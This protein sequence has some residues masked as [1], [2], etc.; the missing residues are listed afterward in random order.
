MM[1]ALKK[2]N[3]EL[4]FLLEVLQNRLQTALQIVV[5]LISF[6]IR[7]YP[8][9]LLQILAF[10]FI[11]S[12]LQAATLGLVLV[13]TRHLEN[14]D[15]INILDLSLNARGPLA[16]G[17]FVS[18]FLTLM[19]VSSVMVF[20]AE[21]L[22]NTVTTDLEASCTEDVYLTL[23][24]SSH[25]PQTYA[26]S[27][28]THHLRST[29]KG[30]PRAVGRGLRVLLKAITPAITTV[31]TLVLALYIN[32]FA[33]LISGILFVGFMLLQFR[34]YQDVIENE[35]RFGLVHGRSR[36]AMNHLLDEVDCMPFDESTLRAHLRYRFAEIDFYEAQKAYV[37]RMMANNRSMFAGNLYLTVAVVTTLSY[38]GYRGIT[39]EAE[40]SRIITYLITLRILLLSIRSLFAL[41]SGL[42]RLSLKISHIQAFLTTQAAPESIL[43]SPYLEVHLYSDSPFSD[44]SCHALRLLQGKPYALMVP[45][46]V[47][48][49][50]ENFFAYHLLGIERITP[51][52][53]IRILGR[54]QTFPVDA[55]LAQLLKVNS[56]AE[57]QGLCRNIPG[58]LLAKVLKQVVGGTSYEQVANYRF[59]SCNGPCSKTDSGLGSW[60]TLKKP[61][62][63]VLSF[64]IIFQDR[65]RFLLVDRVF[66]HRQ[67]IWWS[68]WMSLFS[69]CF[70]FVVYNIEYRRNIGNYGEN[71]VL[72]ADYVG[73]A[74]I[75]EPAQGEE[76]QSQFS[77][78]TMAQARYFKS[79]HRRHDF[80][81]DDLDEDL[82]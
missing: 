5:W 56:E 64:A 14:S 54:Q 79:L 8:F 77:S 67:R 21:V 1:T 13:Y 63:D 36:Q 66:A 70:I 49:V 80:D 57:L 75:G 23:G 4:I 28:S 30:Y 81:F 78:H 69:D 76:L 17:T 20:Q 61:Q 73:I 19:F 22:V 38:L 43:H 40:W 25:Q 42:A 6:P 3:H 60:E 55:P 18:L 10:T 9:R 58:N 31:F 82:M 72:L 62:Q 15:S 74:F 11:G 47:S 65:P 12:S 37:K 53:Y 2:I 34:I 32:S 35:R 26:V 52:H 44:R 39:G 33:T 16:F 41:L 27:N 46:K 59:T 68:Q 24:G 71:K 48:K 50:A 29:V 7:Y 51:G 45:V